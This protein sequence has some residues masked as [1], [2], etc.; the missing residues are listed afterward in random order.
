MTDLQLLTTKEVLALLNT[1]WTTLS[2]YIN[3][4]ALP[5]I[6]CGPKKLNYRPQAIADFERLLEGHDIADHATTGPVIREGM[7]KLGHPIIRLK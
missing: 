4:G 6:R 5:V 2:P 7:A 3:S 1:S